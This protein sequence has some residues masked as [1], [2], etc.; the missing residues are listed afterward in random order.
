[1]TGRSVR[2]NRTGRDGTVADNA[3]I[4]RAYNDVSPESVGSGTIERAG[5][6]RGALPDSFRHPAMMETNVGPGVH[7]GP[8]SLR[9]VIHP[10]S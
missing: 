9:P 5:R 2:G 8:S 10:G 6:E 4:M 3:R 7:P 1:M